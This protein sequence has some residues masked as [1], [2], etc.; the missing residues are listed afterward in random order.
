MELKSHLNGAYTASQRLQGS[1]MKHK[2][3]PPFHLSLITE[4][5]LPK[6]STISKMHGYILHER[7]RFLIWAG[8]LTFPAMSALL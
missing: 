7:S 6:V 4:D 5:Q 1:P 2:E 8:I 3:S